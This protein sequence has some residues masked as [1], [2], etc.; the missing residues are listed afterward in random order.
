ME[1]PLNCDK[2]RELREKAGLTQEEAA[3]RA[4]LHTRQNWNNIESGRRT[5]VTLSTLE[6]IAQ[7]LGV[8]A[9]DLLK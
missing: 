4:G 5:N 8:R 9:A 6:A 1:V 7:A 3:R 2:I